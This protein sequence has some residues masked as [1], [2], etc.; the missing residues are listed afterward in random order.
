MKESGSLWT[1][2]LLRTEQGNGR[3]RGRAQ[4]NS[5]VLRKDFP[6]HPHPPSK[7]GL[8]LPVFAGLCGWQPRRDEPGHLGH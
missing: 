5:G 7:D 8:C 6:T 3:S 4:L 2:C 1:S